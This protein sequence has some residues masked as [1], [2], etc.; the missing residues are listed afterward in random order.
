MI[1]GKSQMQ[2]SKQINIINITPGN[3][4]WQNNYNDHVIRNDTEYKRIKQYIKNNPLNW[5]DDKF[6]K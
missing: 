5:K 6:Y 1:T 4:N 2:T 3:K